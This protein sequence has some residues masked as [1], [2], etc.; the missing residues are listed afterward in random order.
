[1]KQALFVIFSVLFLFACV[2]V[3]ESTSEVV[4]EK[5]LL[6][7]LDSGIVFLQSSDVP[8]IRLRGKEVLS[9]FYLNNLLISLLKSS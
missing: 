5:N 4:Q 1:M 3:Q 8:L 6:P 7:P 9:D 2:R